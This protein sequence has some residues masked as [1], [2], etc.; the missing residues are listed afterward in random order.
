MAKSDAEKLLGKMNDDL[1]LAM[2][3]SPES[4]SHVD[5]WISSGSL[6]LDWIMGGGF[7]VGRIVE[8][9][10]DTS[11]GKSLIA[12]QLVVEAQAEGYITAFIDTESAVSLPLMEEVGVDVDDLIYSTPDTIEDVFEQMEALI[13][14]KAKHAPDQILVVI[15]DTVAATSVKTEIQEK[16]GKSMM[17]RHANLMSQGMRK[18]VKK[19]AKHDVCAVFLN[20]TRMKIGVAFGDPE[21]T[22]GGK[23]LPF[24]SSIRVRLKEA[25]KIKGKTYHKKRKVI[26]GVKTRAEIVKNKVAKPFR[27]VTLPIYFG[28]GVDD[29]GATLELLKDTGI[30]ETRGSWYYLMNGDEEVANFQTSGWPEVY[31]EHYDL[32]EELIW[33][34]DDDLIEESDDGD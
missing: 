2:L 14:A 24:Y 7:P 13:D 21:T 34:I 27:F 17:G 29:D 16:Y 30:I 5:H 20:Q 4:L 33:S 19:I 9:Y 8:I 15:W 11:T 23:A 31:D 32:I 26:I 1:G 6:P 18:I 25:G 10:G 12:T 22:F 28:H 3:G